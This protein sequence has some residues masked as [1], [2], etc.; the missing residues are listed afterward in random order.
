MYQT[1]YGRGGIMAKYEK[2]KIKIEDAAANFVY[3]LDD[4][5]IKSDTWLK[6][7]LSHLVNTAAMLVT[8]VDNV[9]LV[10]DRKLFVLHYYIAKFLH[11]QKKQFGKYKKA[12]LTY[13][14]GTV[15]IAVA[16][17]ALFSYATGYEYS[18]NGKHLGYVNNQED[19]TKVLDLVSEELSKEY[20]SNIQINEES[21]ITFESVFILDKEIDNIDTVLKRL[22]YMSDMKAEAY[23]IFIDGTLFVTVESEA[24]A[25]AVLS[26]VYD[27]YVKEESSKLK[28]EE[29]GFKE[30]VQIQQIDTKLAY[31][32]S[33][34]Q[35]TKK[36][37]KG[38]EKEL[39][40]K[41]KS[42]DTIYGICDKLDVTW[43]ELKEMN[44]GLK[45]E[46]IYP[47]DTILLN[48]ATAAVTVRTV[49]ISTFGEKVKYK[50]K[51]KKSSDMYEGE[52]RVTQEGQY[53][54]R[55]VTARLTRDNGEIVKRKT[56]ESDVII[57]PVTEVIVEG[58]AP[59]P[60]TLPTGTLKYPVYGAVLTSEF[61]W[62][63]GRNHD[64]VDW[65]CGVGTPIYAAD[66]G[67]VTYTGWFGGYGL[68]VEISHGSGVSTAYAHLND[69]YVSNGEA[70]YQG[71]QIGTSGNTGYSTGPHLHFEVMVNGSVQDPLQYLH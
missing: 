34:K 23:G 53:G 20:D 37:M 38:G 43:D 42:G 58:T 47:G 49:E 39:T 46:S 26:N 59:S 22:T 61:G 68:Y 55:V 28:Y 33:V 48:R 30:D 3:W 65:G 51:Y 54:K 52:S 8:F 17:V 50:T 6:T 24:A 40:Y 10:V 12:L 13:F 71:Q 63:W 2:F 56:L 21:D 35:A 15:A 29:I 14:A 7:A 11:K 44:P 25:K 32:S 19:V 27:E 64:G 16:V 31:I 69:I 9:H 41:V 1:A 62:R 36:I 4:T 66:G 60:K 18:Y 57:E 45:Q 5:L 67:T 70:V